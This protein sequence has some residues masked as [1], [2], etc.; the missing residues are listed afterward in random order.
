MLTSQ[1]GDTLGE[2]RALTSPPTPALRNG[3]EIFQLR[4]DVRYAHYNAIRGNAIALSSARTQK[5]KIAG[6]EEMLGAY[7][8]KIDVDHKSPTDAAELALALIAVP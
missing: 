7:N 4:L 8:H 1:Q 6:A 3:G 5:G 2:I